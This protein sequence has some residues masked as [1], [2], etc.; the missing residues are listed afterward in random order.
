MKTKIRARPASRKSPAAAA[1]RPL[2][3]VL[4]PDLHGN[5]LKYVTECVETNWISS[6]GRFNDLFEARFREYCKVPH[7]LA[8]NNGTAALHLALVTLGVKEGDEVLVP[9]ITF[10]ACANAVL[11][12][13][14]TPILVDVDPKTWTMDVKAAERAITPRTKVIMPVHLYGH[15]CDMDAILALAKARGL[16]V[17]EDC[18]QALGSEYKG[19]PL[20]S[21][22]DAAIFSFYGNKTATTGE[23]GMILFQYA[24]HYR[25]AH[26]LRSHGMSKE[27]RYWH[28]DAGY[29]Y[30]MTNIQAAIGV[31]QMERIGEFV[32][33]KRR[34]AKAYIKGLSGVEGLRMPAEEKGAFNSYWLF[35]VLLDDRL[36]SHRDDILRR[37]SEKGIET[38]PL[39]YPLHEMPPYKSLQRSLDFPVSG[40]LSRSGISLPS[41]YSLTEEQ[42][43]YVVRTLTELVRDVR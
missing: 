5:E 1:P 11:H 20:G 9:D 26:G 39:F 38:R 18:A 29:N 41:S 24:D 6:L 3:P 4:E 17:L 32:A 10:A 16:R 2:I 25:A 28:V 31:A 19:R 35:T 14:A 36:A 21:F 30:R 8:V 27:K 37:L 42:L 12:A 23:G 34:I 33:A 13:R 40:R 7:A 15:P 22:G 43:D